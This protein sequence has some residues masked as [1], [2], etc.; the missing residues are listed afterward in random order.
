MC[1]LR[2]PPLPCAARDDDAPD[3]D[4]ALSD[5]LIGDDV[6]CINRRPRVRLIFIVAGWGAV[7]L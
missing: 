4:P 7:N 2:P 1:Q 3:D 6:R 5:W